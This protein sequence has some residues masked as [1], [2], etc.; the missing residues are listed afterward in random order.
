MEH[1][2]RSR[3]GYERKRISPSVKPHYHYDL[4]LRK[5]HSGLVDEWMELASLNLLIM[6][7]LRPHSISFKASFNHSV[8]ILQFIQDIIST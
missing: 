4:R 2:K 5:G 1:G 3:M 7:I 8:P 6:N